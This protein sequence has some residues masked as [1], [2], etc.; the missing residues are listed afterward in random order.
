MAVAPEPDA[1]SA[2]W[3]DGLRQ[4]RVVLQ[5]CDAC[6]RARFPAMPACPW[7]GSRLV[8]AIDATGRGTIYSYVVAHQAVS[9]GYEGR[10]PYAVAT[11]ELEEGP[12][13]LGHVLPPE[14]ASIGAPVTSR[15]VE[16]D[17]W[18]ELQFEVVR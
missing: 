8:T 5:R 15:F 7:C 14:R 3:W 6:R 2:A 9:P 10:L 17:G 16:R 11:V 18:T 12:R 13:V 4:H 1:E